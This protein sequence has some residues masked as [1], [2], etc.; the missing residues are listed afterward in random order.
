MK[1]QLRKPSYQ[2]HLTLGKYRYSWV[3]LAILSLITRRAL[4]SSPTCPPVG[5]LAWCVNNI[6]MLFLGDTINNGSRD[7]RT[8]DLCKDHR[9]KCAISH[10]PLYSFMMSYICKTQ[11]VCKTTSM[12]SYTHRGPRVKGQMHN[13]ELLALGWLV[14]PHCLRQVFF[15]NLATF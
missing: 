15:L 6:S 5:C 2:S 8:V 11:F 3:Y 9:P 12:T 4:Q 1:I 7:L 14:V 10:Y 13:H